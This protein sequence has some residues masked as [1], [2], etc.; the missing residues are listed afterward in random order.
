[1]EYLVKSFNFK[2]PDIL[3]FNCLSLHTFQ[4]KCFGIHRTTL[5]QIISIFRGDSLS[6]SQVFSH[7]L[8]QSGF[9][10]LFNQTN[11]ILRTQSIKSNPIHPILSIKSYP[12]NPIHPIQSYPSNHIHAILSMQPYPCNPIHAILSIQS[13]PSIQSY[14]SNPIHTILFLSIQLYPSNPINPILFIQFY[15]SNSINP[16]KKAK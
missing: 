5:Q 6:R 4:T 12:P 3:E 10:K 13:Y 8:T 16:T 1:V 14:A 7:S 15:S 9:L 11:P 2:I